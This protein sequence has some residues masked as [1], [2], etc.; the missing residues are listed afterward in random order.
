MG[1]LDDIKSCVI[2]DLTNIIR[3]IPVAIP[4]N[5]DDKKILNIGQDMFKCMIDD[6][7]NG[8]ISSVF[9]ITSLMQDWETLRPKLTTMNNKEVYDIINKITEVIEDEE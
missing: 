5:D 3:Y 8:Q 2:T 1:K 6:I 7:N 4:E 9:D